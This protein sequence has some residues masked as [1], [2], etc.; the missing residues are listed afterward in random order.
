M[1]LT[2]MI[3]GVVL[4]CAVLYQL[5]F[6]QNNRIIGSDFAAYWCATKL[7]VS[8]INPYGDISLDITVPVCGEIGM[9]RVFNFPWSFMFLSPLTFLDVETAAAVLAFVTMAAMVLTAILSCKTYNSKAVPLSAVLLTLLSA[10]GIMALRIGHFTQLVA[11]GLALSLYLK[12]RGLIFFSGLALSFILFKPHTAYLFVAFILLQSVLEWRPRMLVGF[13]IGVVSCSVAAEIIHPGAFA[14]WY[15]QPSLPFYFATPTIPALLSPF[16][17][18]QMHRVLCVVLPLCA[19]L[20][21][22]WFA[23][24]NRGR[25]LSQL[26]AAILFSGSLVVSPYNWPFDFFNLILCQNRSLS[27]SDYAIRSYL[28]WGFLSIMALWELG[29][30]GSYAD[31]FWLPFATVLIVWLAST[32]SRSKDLLSDRVI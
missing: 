23:I 27:E 10:A 28:F 2:C 18:S 15:G 22:V 21:V 16:V 1:K 31:F 12:S 19:L 14:Q 32:K 9:Q 30:P 8:G 5:C 25:T 20:A 11:F 4:A 6:P 17:S 24:R 7:F 3:A 26:P 29:V 13:F